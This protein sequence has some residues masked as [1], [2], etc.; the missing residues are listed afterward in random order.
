MFPTGDLTRMQA[1]QQAHMMDVCHRAVYSRTQSD[2]GA[3]IEVW[4]ESTVD[5]PCGIDQASMRSDAEKVEQK[6]TVVLYDAVVR[7]PLSQAEVWDMKDRLVLTQRFGSAI[8]PITYGISSPIVRGP[9][10]IRMNLQ[11]IEV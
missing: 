9:S 10:G 7:L 6:M 4:T 8:T 11:K 5:I 2:S 3:D 1:V